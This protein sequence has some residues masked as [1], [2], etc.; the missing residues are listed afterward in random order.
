MNMVAMHLRRFAAEATRGLGIPRSCARIIEVLALTGRRLSFGELA[1]RVRISERS[2]RSHIRILVGKG[3][4][5]RAVAVTRQRR[6]AYEYYIAPLGDIVGL[7]RQELAAK[8]R[9]LQD[10][11]HEVR[12][13]RRAP[14]V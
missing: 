14:A 9:R 6:L 8:I 10:L 3:I 2:L 1:R 7:V 11:S 5:R 4:L 12:G 13:T